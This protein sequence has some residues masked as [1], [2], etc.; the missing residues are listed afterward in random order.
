MGEALNKFRFNIPVDVVEKA[1][2]AGQEWRIGGFVS[3]DHLDRQQ[4][5][6]L[7]DGLDFGPFMKS[8]FFNDNHSSSSADVLGYP[9]SAEMRNTPDGHKGWYVE[10]YLLKEAPKAQSIWGIC[11]SLV[12]TSR[13]FGFSV[14]GEVT[15]RDPGNRTTV[16]KAVVNHVAITHCP[17]N[18]RAE[19][20]VL[21]K[22]LSVGH[23]GATAGVPVNGAGAAAIT[24]P[25][26][27][28][29]L[30]AEEREKLLKKRRLVSKSDAVGYLRAQ[31]IPDKLV[32]MVVNSAAYSA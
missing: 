15:D 12:G 24:T 28:D 10:G 31:G 8:G 16:R 6:L 30:T 7:Q 21:A 5:V 14:E 29:G 20:S 2:A 11:K 27:L 25:E 19:L 4:E 32:Q 22:S 17:I 13:K 3:T 26:S 1:G 23:S 18:T 9:L